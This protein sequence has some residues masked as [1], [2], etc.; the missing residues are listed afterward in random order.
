MQDQFPG[1]E[2]GTYTID[3]AHSTVTFTV[4]HMM[5]TKVRGE[6]EGVEGTIVLGERPEDSTVE[7]S[8]DPTTISTRNADRDAHLRSPDFFATDEHPTWTFRSTGVRQDG[9]D[10]VVDGDL[11]MR[12]VTKPVSL[13]LEFGGFVTD[14]SGGKRVGASA[15]TRVKRTDFGINWNAALETGGV[16]VS[17]DVDVELEISAVSD[18]PANA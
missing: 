11:Q 1:Y 13:A 14:P 16:V 4:R 2:P 3:P 7:A 5:V 12:G 9:D 6:M 10:L 8:I 15:R 17:D 18:A